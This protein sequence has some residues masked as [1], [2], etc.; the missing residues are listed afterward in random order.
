[1]V[2]FTQDGSTNCQQDSDCPFDDQT[3]EDDPQGRVCYSVQE[4]CP[5][6]S[7]LCRSE[8]SNL[9]EFRTWEECLEECSEE[10]CF[11]PQFTVAAGY[12]KTTSA[13]TGQ[14][15]R[16]KSVTSTFGRCSPC[17]VAVALEGL[18]RLATDVRQADLALAK[19]A[20]V[21]TWSVFL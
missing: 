17:L 12:L 4:H 18:V 19:V 2:L 13:I 14:S 21:A 9:K 7:V 3:C 5:E 15:F 20:S 8:S 11:V 6:F 16:L 10:E 1:M